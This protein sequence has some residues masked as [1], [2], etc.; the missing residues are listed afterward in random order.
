MDK[1]NIEIKTKKI[2]DEQELAQLNGIAKVRKEI[3][4]IER[5]SL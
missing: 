4:I 1:V 3:T 2:G 5:D